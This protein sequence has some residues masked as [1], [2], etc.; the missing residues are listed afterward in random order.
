M[1]LMRKL[2]Q[3]VDM[4]VVWQV[5]DTVYDLK[6][7]KGQEVSDDYIVQLLKTEVDAN[8]PEQPQQPE[9]PEQPEQLQPQQPE[10]PK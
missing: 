7:N 5:A 4:H 9:Q 8:R 10:Q 3:F 1:Q 2:G 6:Y